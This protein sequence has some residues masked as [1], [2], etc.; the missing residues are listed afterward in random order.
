MEMAAKL[1]FRPLI[2]AT[3]ACGLSATA[4][5]A[6]VIDAGTPGTTGDTALYIDDPAAVTA[7]AGSGASAAELARFVGVPDLN[8][9]NGVREYIGLGEFFVTY[10]LGDFRL[11]DGS[12]FDFNVYEVGGGDV[13]FGILDVLVSANG[14]DFFSV[15]NATPASFGGARDLAGDGIT[16]NIASRQS[17][18]IGG[19]VAALGASEFQYIRLNGLPTSF[20]GGQ[21]RTANIGNG[22]D[23]DTIGIAN[24]TAA[25]TMS[26]VPEPGTWLMMILGFGLI[27]GSMRNAKSAQPRTRMA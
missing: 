20:S 27:G 10:D 15:A 23:L 5:A 17:Y 21:I 18:D 13:E 12:G 2:A 9:D 16:A 14:T 24:F 26:A 22:F 6:T 11:F 4:Q 3:L 7:E 19:A 25:S 8:L 1:I